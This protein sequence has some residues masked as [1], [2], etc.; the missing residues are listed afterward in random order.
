MTGHRLENG[1]FKDQP[2]VYVSSTQEDEDGSSR[3]QRDMARL[4]KKQE[5]NVKK[6]PIF[7]ENTAAT[8]F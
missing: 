3:D 1:A 4:G 5:L 6:S 2:D 7:S 8:A